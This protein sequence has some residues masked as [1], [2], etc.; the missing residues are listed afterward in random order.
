MTRPSQSRETES[1]DRPSHSIFSDDIQGYHSSLLGSNDSHKE[2]REETIPPIITSDIFTAWTK[3]TAPLVPQFGLLAGVNDGRYPALTDDPR[4]FFNVTPPSSTFIC[5]SQ[6][7]GKS[8]TLSCMLETCLIS[9]RAGCLSKPLTGLVFHYDT[10]ISDQM[11]SPCEAA[12]LSSSPDVEVRVLCAPTNVHAI[13]GAYSRLGVKVSA[14]EIDQ[15]HLNTK[16]M[17][18]LMAVGQDDGQMP[19]YMHTVKRI[20]RE[21][22]VAQQET[23]TV[24]NYSAFKKMVM[25]STLTPAQLEPLKQRLDMLESFMPR[26]QTSTRDKKNKYPSSASSKGTDWEP[27]ARRLTILDLSCP[28]IS[29]ET[30]CSLFNICLGIFLEQ[31]PQIGRVVALDEAHKYMNSSPEARGFTETLLSAVRLQ[32]HL[33]IRMIIS[34]QEPTVSTAL[35][36]L[37]STTIVH[38]FTSPEWLRI[39]HKHLAGAGEDA[40]AVNELQ[41]GEPNNSSKEPNTQSSLFNK[42]VSLRVGEAIIF[43]PSTIIRVRGVDEDGKLSFERL[44]N[45]NVQVRVRQRLTLDG[46]RSLLCR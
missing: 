12:F 42:I 27:K 23:Q 44:G 20:L 46:G 10:F 26:E 8:H 18:D 28:C 45:G 15:G 37:C 41:A 43:S 34:T 9:S 40:V 6:G 21:M 3:N 24:F 36:N 11:G 14:L 19:L 29:P 30:A 16:R 1:S 39:L 22:R 35:L 5:G 38:H 4:L 31:D 7:S 13:R 32:R 17:L 25:D 33:G 2:L